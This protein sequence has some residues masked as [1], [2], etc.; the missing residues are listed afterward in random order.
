[1]K[2]VI[3]TGFN[4][5][6][7]RHACGEFRRRGYE[8]QGITNGQVD[9]SARDLVDTVTICDL[10]SPDVVGGLEI[11]KNTDVILNLAGFATNTGGDAELI[12]HI[13]TGVHVNMCRRLGGLGLSPI[14]IGVSSST[15]YR[16]DQPLPL[17]ESSMRKDQA[18]ARPYE[19]SKI[20]MEN[21][22]REFPN[23][24]IVIAR[25]FNHIG[26]GQGPGFLIPDL[27]IQ[28]LRAL[29]DGTPLL[30]GNLSSKRDYTWVEDVVN[31]Y[32]DLAELQDF[33]PGEVFNI[34]SGRSISGEDVLA[35]L[36]KAM[37]VEES[38]EIQVDP[39]KL[40]GASDVD[41]NYGSYKK[42]HDATGWSPSENGV[43]T[44][45]KLF[46]DDFLARNK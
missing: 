35:M 28:I 42:I 2:K 18:D 16:P 24:P 3:I 26:K 11:D 36:L 45:I 46:A 21:L 13:N 9:D 20:E 14:Y 30:V 34:C 33:E 19:A 37:G 8:I 40:R 38:L 1:M 29:K 44:G 27:A 6:V 4:G 22:L 17:T 10:A 39:T 5:F 7:G 32:A 25:P 43:Q 15:V 23:L 31:A 12:R 41:D